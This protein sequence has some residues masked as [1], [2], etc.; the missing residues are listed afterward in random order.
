MRFI[1][2]RAL[3]VSGLDE[4]SSCEM[5]MNVLV[6]CTD[7]GICLEAKYWIRLSGKLLFDRI[8]DLYPV[9]SRPAQS[10]KR[11]KL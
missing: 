6:R 3:A 7:S 2:L 5:R 10:I 8:S 1:G 4:A 11:A 9:K